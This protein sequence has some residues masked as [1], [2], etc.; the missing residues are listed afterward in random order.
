[1]HRAVRSGGPPNLLIP[2]PPPSFNCTLALTR[3]SRGRVLRLVIGLVVGAGSALTGTSGPVLLLPIVLSLHWH[4][5]AAL[6]SG[7]FIQLPIATAATIS[8]VTLRPGVLDFELGGVLAA[9]LGPFIFLGLFGWGWLA[10]GGDLDDLVSV[11]FCVRQD[12]SIVCA[13]ARTRL[14]RCVSSIVLT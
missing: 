5:H 4:V 1:L 10:R 2:P 14:R 6:S 12:T 8:Y 11:L 3:R 7:L 9:T 13:C